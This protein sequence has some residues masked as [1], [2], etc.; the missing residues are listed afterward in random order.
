MTNKQVLIDL[1]K[2]CSLKTGQTFTLSSGQTSQTY[3]DIKKTALSSAGYKLL[4]KLL[5]D[6]MI[7]NFR[8]VEAVAGVAL[9]GCHL[10]SIVAMYSTINLDTIY[11]RKEAKTH[12]TQQLIEQPNCNIGEKVVLFEDVITTGKS[13]INAAKLLQQQ[14]FE[15]LGIVAVVDRR[16]EKLSTLGDFPVIFLVDFEDLI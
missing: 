2:V 13:V 8:S 10:A 12:G 16:A 1:L 11:I 14:G 6:A 5:Y 3:I 15:V 7:T 4:A 9:G